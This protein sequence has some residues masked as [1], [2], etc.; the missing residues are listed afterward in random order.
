MKSVSDTQ[1]S[2][3]DYGSA[4]RPPYTVSCQ[5]DT[6]ARNSS[7]LVQLSPVT[8][9]TSQGR[10]N[11]GVLWAL[12]VTMAY[13]ERQLGPFGLAKFIPLLETRV[14]VLSTLHPVGLEQTN[15]HSATKLDSNHKVPTD[16]NLKTYYSMLIQRYG[17]TENLAQNRK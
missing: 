16:C 14:P 7:P 11:L 5:P 12:K 13:L 8:T 4:R 3:R 9:R 15:K 10:I 6:C 2:V 17:H 1:G